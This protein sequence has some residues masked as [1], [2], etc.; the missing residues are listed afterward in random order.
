MSVVE[1]TL[2]E[3]NLKCNSFLLFTFCNNLKN[4][5]FEFDRNSLEKYIY[6]ESS[7]HKINTF[8]NLLWDSKFYDGYTSGELFKK[9]I[10]H[11]F[12]NDNCQDIL[13][14]ISKDFDNLKKRYINYKFF[15]FHKYE[16]LTERKFLINLKLFMENQMRDKILII[17]LVKLWCI[18]NVDKETLREKFIPLA[19]SI[20]YENNV[21][22]KDYFCK[23]ANDDIKNEFYEIFL[24]ST[25]FEN[26]NSNNNIINI[27]DNNVKKVLKKH[28][29]KL[30]YFLDYV[31]EE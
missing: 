11:Y 5:D 6:R 18:I 1:M 4:V 24:A 16:L 31:P 28:T 14:L 13:H 3:K 26:S 7:P 27:V 19:F 2:A 29:L 20:W 21:F 8:E 9:I 17:S 23:I 22:Y 30:F 12:Y 15:L 25:K 10:R